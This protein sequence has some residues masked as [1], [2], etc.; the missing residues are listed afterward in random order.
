[1]RSEDPRKGEGHAR[2]KLKRGV[3]WRL[4]LAQRRRVAGQ[5]GGSREKKGHAGNQSNERERG[6]KADHI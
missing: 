6:E 3:A 4:G 2:P 1:M 5:A